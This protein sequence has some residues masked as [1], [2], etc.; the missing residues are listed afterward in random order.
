MA[1]L[2]RRKTTMFEC[3]QVLRAR[4]LP[5]QVRVNTGDFAPLENTIKVMTIRVSKGL[6]FSVVAIPGVGQMPEEG[7]EVGDEARLF[8]VAA[9]RATQ[10]L[11]LTVSAS[12]SFGT[13]LEP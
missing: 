13:C 5:H 9:T 7:N 11:I 2:C 4:G 12:G 3:A 8:Y 1:I 6:E 10:R